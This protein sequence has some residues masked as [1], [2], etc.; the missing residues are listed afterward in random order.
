MDMILFQSILAYAIVSH[1]AA[2]R[3]RDRVRISSRLFPAP[4]VAASAAG[5]RNGIPRADLGGRDCL[6]VQV[7]AMNTENGGGGIASLWH[8]HQSPGFITITVLHHVR[9]LHPAKRFKDLAKIVPRHI[10]GHITYTDI[11][12]VPLSS[13]SNTCLLKAC[14][15]KRNDSGDGS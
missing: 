1:L 4:A 7:P 3:C 5:P 8:A 11:H 15:T 2:E 12:S 13:V 10:T 6:P 9:C 14:Q